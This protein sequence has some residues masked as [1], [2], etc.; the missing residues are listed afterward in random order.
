DIR[1][2]V[3]NLRYFGKLFCREFVNR[4][5]RVSLARGQDD[6]WKP[7]FVRRIGKV[8]RLKTKTV[9]PL[10]NFAVLSGDT[11]VKKVSGI[12]LNTGF[13]C[14]DL[15]HAAGSRLVSPGRER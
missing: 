4:G 6:G 5:L 2:Q 14:I 13:S 7:R 3:S 8:L 9:A 12:Q 11:A 1:S 10:V 15:H